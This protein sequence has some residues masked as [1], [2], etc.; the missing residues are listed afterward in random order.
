MAD[1][2]TK[3]KL[4]PVEV[5]EIHQWKSELEEFRCKNTKMAVRIRELSDY[6]AKMERYNAMLEQEKKIQQKEVSSTR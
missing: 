2:V 1:E 6:A 5:R 4:S 3:F